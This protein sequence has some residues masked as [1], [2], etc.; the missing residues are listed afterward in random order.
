LSAAYNLEAAGTTD[1]LL[2]EAE[3]RPGGW[4]KTDWT[5]PYGS[6]RAV[7]ALYF[8]DS[9]IEGWVRE[10]LD[11]S[12]ITHRKRCL[13]DSTGVRTPFP[14]HANLYGRPRQVVEE[15]LSGLWQA[16][17]EQSRL[18]ATPATFA[19]WINLSYGA[20]VA[21]HFMNP[22]NSKMWTVPP[23]AMEWQWTAGFVPTIS[24]DRILAGALKPLESGF[25]WNATFHYPHRGLSAL[26]DALASRVKPIRY[27]VA[28]SGI[29][30][31]DGVA[32]LSDGSSIEYSRLVSTI[33]LKSIFGLFRPEPYE[34]AGA[35]SRLEA[36]D[37]V[38]ID[39]GFRGRPD[40]DVHW[41]YL[42]DADILP[43]RLQL[44][45]SF[46][47]AL[48]PSGCGLYC[49]EVSHSVH[50]PLPSGSLSDRVIDDLIRTGWLQSRDQVEFVRERRFP[51]AY[52]IPR[53]G[54]GKD[55]ATLREYLL[56]WNIWSVGRY[57]EW[58]Y[59]NMEQ[60]LL[61]GERAAE[62]VMAEDVV[63]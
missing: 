47:D 39:I 11:D 41:V 61:D 55:V 24:P 9:R 12:W 27:G 42:P 4:A 2:I 40:D 32:L 29:L 13:V 6:D 33:P 50:R 38:L 26:S 60:A 36:L 52:V 49:A 23:S 8:R 22:Y 17:L 48:V 21:A 3:N 1:Y 43:Y 44:V 25:G 7:H 62:L 18:P 63:V 35:L 37:L 57:G 19:D 46:S 10:L 51:C 28:L 54:H 31:A 34:V 59:S 15:C 53:L 16:S 56:R 5:G 45:H 30:P 58:K 20:G 14:F